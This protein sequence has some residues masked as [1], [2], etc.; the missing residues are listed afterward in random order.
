[1]RRDSP[2]FRPCHVFGVLRYRAGLACCEAHLPITHPMNTRLAR[3]A[4]LQ[5]GKVM[6]VLYGSI[7]LIFVPFILIIS[8]VASKAGDSHFPMLFVIFIPII[9][10]VA[11][12]IGGLLVAAIYNVI[13]GWTGGVHFTIEDAPAD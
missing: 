9:Y 11:G 1:M 13:A 2:A 12:F 5:L 4:P 6:A 10:A 3:V 7:S 8:M